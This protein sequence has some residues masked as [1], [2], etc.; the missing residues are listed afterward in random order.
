ML[1]LDRT[2]Q[3]VGFHAD[4]DSLTDGEEQEEQEVVILGPCMDEDPDAHEVGCP[5]EAVEPQRVAL[6]VLVLGH[7]DRE[8]VNEKAEDDGQTDGDPGGDPA[9]SADGQV[10]YEVLTG[11]VREGAVCQHGVPVGQFLK[12][13]HETFSFQMN[14]TRVFSD[15][16]YDFILVLRRSTFNCQFSEMWEI[17]H[18]N[19]KF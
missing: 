2:G 11:D 7:D 17:F 6:D 8:D 16:T 10:I 1:V 15:V 12:D 4:P 5:V 3:T 19:I 9:G 13:V 18:K 14:L